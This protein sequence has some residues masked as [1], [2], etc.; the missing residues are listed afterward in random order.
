VPIGEGEHIWVAGRSKTTRARLGILNIRVE[1]AGKE[2][3]F[4]ENR[5][6]RL[7]REEHEEEARWLCDVTSEPCQGGLLA[8]ISLPQTASCGT[9]CQVKDGWYSVPSRKKNQRGKGDQKRVVKGERLC[10]G[11]E[12]KR[13]KLKHKLVIIYHSYTTGCT[14]NRVVDIGHPKPLHNPHHPARRVSTGAH[15]RS[16]PASQ[17]IG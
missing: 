5:A 17:H 7:L 3:Q 6:E 14:Y 1:D 4:M 15:M 13:A 9:H 11:K 2:G 12:E 8:G 16:I 10:K